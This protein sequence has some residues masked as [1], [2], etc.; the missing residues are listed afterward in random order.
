MCSACPPARAWPQVVDEAKKR[1]VGQA[2]DYDT[3]KAMVSVAHLTP[4]NA[5]GPQGCKLDGGLGRAGMDGRE[6][7]VGGFD[8]VGKAGV[9][10]A[11]LLV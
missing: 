8:V 10:S 9:N 6:A 1:A 5:G 7:E 2:V 11:A 3:F 4:I